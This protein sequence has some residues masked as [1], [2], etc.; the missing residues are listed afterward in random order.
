MVYDLITERFFRTPGP[1]YLVPN[2]LS[3][4]FCR[5]INN[6]YK[7]KESGVCNYKDNIV[8]AGG[9]DDFGVFSSCCLFDTSTGEIKKF[10]DLVIPRKNPGRCLLRP[11]TSGDWLLVPW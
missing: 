8:F 10:P 3:A 4:F 5:S 11:K 7:N 2:F 1:W 6:T 9:C